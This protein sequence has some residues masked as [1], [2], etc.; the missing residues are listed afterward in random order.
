[1]YFV[2]YLDLTRLNL[3]SLFYTESDWDEL[4]SDVE[5]EGGAKF[6]DSLTD[7]SATGYPSRFLS[8]LDQKRFKTKIVAQLLGATR[9]DIADQLQLKG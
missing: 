3:L 5:D 2:I 4:S 7:L 1:M 6:I 8:L 9:R